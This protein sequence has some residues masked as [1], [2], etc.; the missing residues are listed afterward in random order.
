MTRHF[1]KEAIRTANKHLEKSLASSTLQN[2]QIKTTVKYHLHPLDIA[3]KKKKKLK[4]NK[5]NTGEEVEKL[6]PSDIYDKTV[7][8]ENS[9]VIP[10]KVRVTI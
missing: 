4:E 7:T 1:S 9:M 10:Q 6:E 2:T 8:V 5:I 3:T